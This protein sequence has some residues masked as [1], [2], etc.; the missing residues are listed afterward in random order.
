MKNDIFKYRSQLSAENAFPELF[1]RPQLC[2]LDIN[3]FW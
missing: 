3:G 1:F 2:L